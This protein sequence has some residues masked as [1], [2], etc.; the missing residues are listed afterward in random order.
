V[1]LDDEIAKLADKIG[2]QGNGL[3]IDEADGSGRHGAWQ[4]GK[5]L[6]GRVRRACGRIVLFQVCAARHLGYITAFRPLA[7]GRF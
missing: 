7:N 1:A 6:H 4:V 5:F 3:G 2:V